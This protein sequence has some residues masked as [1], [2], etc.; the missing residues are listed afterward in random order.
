MNF[1]F[2][3]TKHDLARFKVIQFENGFFGVRDTQDNWTV[4][5]GMDKTSAIK[6]AERCNIREYAVL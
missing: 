2:I 5:F 3:E 4:S 1:T 6:Q